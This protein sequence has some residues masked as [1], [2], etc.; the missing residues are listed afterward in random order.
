[1]GIHVPS[2]NL[3]WRKHMYLNEVTF[4]YDL[5]KLLLAALAPL[6]FPLG[7]AEISIQLLSL[8]CGRCNYCRVRW[9][10]SNASS[11]SSDRRLIRPPFNVFAS[12]GYIM[13]ACEWCEPFSFSRCVIAEVI[14]SC[15]QQVY[16]LIYPVIR[17][18]HVGPVNFPCGVNCL[19]AWISRSPMSRIL[20]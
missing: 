17:L 18:A 10:L 1:M 13:P 5:L 20:R 16:A 15:C 14:K 12:R 3:I 9:S 6:P 2:T 4:Q 8:S 11:T 7:F 19:H